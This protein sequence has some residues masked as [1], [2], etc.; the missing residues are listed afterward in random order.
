MKRMLSL[1]GGFLLLIAPWGA[2]D[3][4]ADDGKAVANKKFPQLVMII[5]HAEKPPE[6]TASVHLSAEG[7]KLA[8]ALPGLFKASDKATEPIPRPRLHLRRQQLQT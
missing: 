4:R 6:E 3:C 1:V 5:R 7:Q 2:A 8:Q